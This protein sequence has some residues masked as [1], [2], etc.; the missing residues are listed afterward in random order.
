VCV[1][2]SKCVNTGTAVFHSSITECVPG[3]TSGCPASFSVTFP[4]AAII[5]DITFD[6]VLH[7]HKVLVLKSFVFLFTTFL[8]DGVATYVS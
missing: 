8:F 5:N 6:C 7:R 3:M 1:F 2:L 4:V